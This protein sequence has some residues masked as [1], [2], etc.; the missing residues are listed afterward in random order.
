MGL[1]IAG[2]LR[3]MDID[4]PSSA[5]QRPTLRIV[6]RDKAGGVEGHEGKHLGGRQLLSV[7][8]TL[9]HFDRCSNLRIKQTRRNYLVCDGMLLDE[10]I[11]VV[12]DIVYR[13]I[14]NKKKTKRLLSLELCREDH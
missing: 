1:E 7:V 12:H 5:R 2:V 6:R 4:Y 8:V 11:N 14:L 3:Q 13:V 9:D 10:T